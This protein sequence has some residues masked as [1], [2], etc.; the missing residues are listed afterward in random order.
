MYS[1]VLLYSDFTLTS[2]AKLDA[3]KNMHSEVA[4]TLFVS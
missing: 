2:P 3:L 4:N 1:I